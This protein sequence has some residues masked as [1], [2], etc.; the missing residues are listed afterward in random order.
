MVK[1]TRGALGITGFPSQENSC[2]DLP[3]WIGDDRLRVLSHHGKAGAAIPNTGRATIYLPEDA[4]PDVAEVMLIHEIGHV[5]LNYRLR[6]RVLLRM[7]TESVVAARLIQELRPRQE[8]LAR[9]FAASWFLMPYHE[10]HFGE[11]DEA[12]TA[13]ELVRQRRLQHS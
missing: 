5:L 3:R 13:A 9:M 7:H 2:H 8:A 1:T 10:V 11:G 12:S 4:P 6:M